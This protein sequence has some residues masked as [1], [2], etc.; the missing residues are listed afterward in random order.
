MD[1]P[2]EH[3]A[4]HAAAPMPMVFSV[5]TDCGPLLF[6]WWHPRSQSAYGLSLLVIF[7]LGASAEWVSAYARRGGHNHGTH[8]TAA[9]ED[10]LTRMVAHDAHGRR[11]S[12]RALSSGLHLAMLNTLSISLHMAVMLL[13]MSFNVGV[14]AAIVLGMSL[15]RTTLG[16]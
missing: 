1:V 9:V 11:K 2:H 14:F 8:T 4:H 7:A 5:S 13:I 6:S 16:R 10:E 3:H 15:C 12:S